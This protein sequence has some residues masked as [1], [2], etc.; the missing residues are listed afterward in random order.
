MDL[1]NTIKLCVLRH[2]SNA[3]VHQVWHKHT[4]KQCPQSHSE[5]A[6]ACYEEATRESDGPFCCEQVKSILIAIVQGM[7]SSKRSFEGSPANTHS[8]IKSIHQCCGRRTQLLSGHGGQ[9]DG[10]QWSLEDGQP[11]AMAGNKMDSLARASK[12]LNSVD[13]NKRV[14]PWLSSFRHQSQRSK[15]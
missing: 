10:Q 7:S 2:G 4:G 11:Y 15:F 13:I 9:Q 5:E 1:D 6:R 8:H 12:A 3:K 14:P